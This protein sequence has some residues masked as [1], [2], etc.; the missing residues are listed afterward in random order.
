MEEPYMPDVNVEAPPPE[1]F[2]EGLEEKRQ[3]MEAARERTQA[4]REV[5]RETLQ[6]VISL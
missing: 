5:D 6:T 1:A 4:Q 2:R 3:E